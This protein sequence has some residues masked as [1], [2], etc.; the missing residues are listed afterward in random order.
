MGRAWYKTG[1]YGRSAA[2][3]RATRSSRFKP[4]H[5]TMGLATSTDP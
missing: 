4:S 2:A 5:M 1:G 3:L